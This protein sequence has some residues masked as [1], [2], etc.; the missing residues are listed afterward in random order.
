[1]EQGNHCI[2]I[3]ICTPCSCHILITKLLYHN[4]KSHLHS[5]PYGCNL[6]LHM[7]TRIHTSCRF[8]TLREVSQHATCNTLLTKSRDLLPCFAC[9]IVQCCYTL[10][11][12]C[13]CSNPRSYCDK[14]VMI[15]LS[16]NV[17]R[18]LEGYVHLF[19]RGVFLQSRT[20]NALKYWSIGREW[21]TLGRKGHLPCT[22][23]GLYLHVPAVEW[24]LCLVHIEAQV[25]IFIAV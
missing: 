16:S 17:Q 24:P 2:I 21:G 15:L 25:K 13:A 20:S 23:W 4:L 10:W 1:M 3:S 12:G 19:W 18:P 7:H 5:K 8:N 22:G 14:I 9:F 6:F 11:V